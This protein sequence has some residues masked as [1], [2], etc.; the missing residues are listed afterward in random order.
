MLAVV[1]VSAPP[2]PPVDPGMGLA[3]E[4]RHLRVIARSL[5][6]LAGDHRLVVVY[7]HTAHL[8]LAGGVDQLDAPVDELNASAQAATTYVLA[9]C[10]SNELT[11]RQAAALVTQVRVDPNDVAFERPTEPIG[12]PFAEDRARLLA[13][14]RGWLVKP[15]AD[16]W[17]RLVPALA[18]LAVVE[19]DA[20]RALLARHIVVVSGSGVPVIADFGGAVRGVA[21]VTRPGAVAAVLAEHLSA[22]HL[23]ILD[24]RRAVG[25]I[26]PSTAQ[27]VPAGELNAEADEDERAAHR[28]TQATGAPAHL[29]HWQRARAVLGGDAGTTV[30]PAAP[31]A[32]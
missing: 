12:P 15:L 29:G 10:L 16:G 13:S 1:S 32:H 31:T 5:A 3:G 2:T 18:P 6:D 25:S 28:F 27:H 9:Q 8:Q 21:G 7:E 14:T 24:D 23:V 19:M 4:R 17:R 26:R 22:D 20:V 30:T 11:S